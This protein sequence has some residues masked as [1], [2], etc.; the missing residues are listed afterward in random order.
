MSELINTQNNQA[1]FR[2]QLLTTVSAFALAGS[3]WAVPDAKADD[4]ERPTVWV[5]LG[6]QLEHM[7]AA[8]DQFVAPFMLGPQPLPAF[9][10]GSISAHP[11]ALGVPSPFANASALD[12]Q[13]PPQSSFGGEGK[14]SFQP[15][16]SDWVLSAAVRYGRSNGTRNANSPLATL[17]PY[18]PDAKYPP[19]V[20]FGKFFDATSKYS[21]S[22]TVLD[23]DVGRDVGLG[24]FGHG[25]S[26]TINMGVRFA[27]FASR[28]S[29]VVNA[30]PRIEAY[31]RAG[32]YPDKYYYAFRFQ[33]YAFNAY[34]VRSFHGIG[35]SL[36]WDGSARLIGNSEAAQINFDWGV[37]AAVLFGRQK[38]STS[39]ATT[40]YDKFLPSRAPSANPQRAHFY[41]HP[42]T[43]VHRVRSVTVPN[44]GAFAGLSFVY[45]S[46]KL[47]FGYRADFFLG[48]MDEGVDARHSKDMGFYGPFAKISVGL[49]G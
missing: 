37:N 6:G 42:A 28:S 7:T 49:G 26:S 41:T 46:A 12:A 29:M 35:P 5:E 45:S 27:Q 3:F 47:S 39:H 1:G 43:P 4:A 13:K 22:H 18:V 2:R 34:S 8:E 33:T 11:V 17:R 16:G 48:A 9:P 23:F 36:S 44:L 38:A 10:F 24:L 21:E 19:A 30:N 25:G 32:S 14:I 40:A 15:K 31:G 20:W